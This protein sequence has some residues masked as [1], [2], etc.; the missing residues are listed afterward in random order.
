MSEHIKAVII[1][2]LSGLISIPG[3]MKHINEK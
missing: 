2:V 1:V 3:Q